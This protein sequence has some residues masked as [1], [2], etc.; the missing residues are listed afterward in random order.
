MKFVGTGTR[1]SSNY[2]NE[3]PTLARTKP[4][5]MGHPPEKDNIKILS[6][7][8]AA[9]RRLGRYRESD[10]VGFDY[11]VLFIFRDGA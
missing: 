10:F 7:E 4:E 9:T 1:R 8:R 6:V 3:R 11:V 2:E 5:R